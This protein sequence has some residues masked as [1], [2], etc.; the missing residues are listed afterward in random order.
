MLYRKIPVRIHT[1]HSLA[2]NEV[3]LGARFLHRLAFRRGVIPVAIAP[4]VLESLRNVYG[5]KSYPMIP[6]GIPVSVYNNPKIGGNEWRKRE[7]FKTDDVIFACVARLAPPK[8]QPLLLEAFLHGPASDSK[9]QL[10]LVGSGEWKF[11]LEKKIHLYGLQKKVRLLGYRTDI[12]EVLGAVD[13][14]VLPSEW[15][16][17]PLCVME[18]MAAGK[19]II[20]TRVGGIPDLVEDGLSGLLI[21][22]NNENALTKA[23]DKLLQNKSMRQKMGRYASQLASA[24]FDIETMAKAYEKLYEKSLRTYI[25]HNGID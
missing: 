5:N 22:P 24:R 12:P 21:P 7:G 16:G 23:L 8:N 25:Q 14:F 2:E 10:L 4:G 18:A 9:A 20:A 11:E 3:G 17:N 13:V 19:P 1:V 15:E 6:N